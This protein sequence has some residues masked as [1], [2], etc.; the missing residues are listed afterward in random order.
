[1]AARRRLG[2]PGVDNEPAL[3]ARHV[4]DHG[5][6]PAAQLG[7]EPA[8]AGAGSAHAGFADLYRRKRAESSPG[9]RWMITIGLVLVAGLGGVVG[10]FMA[11]GAQATLFAALALVVFGPAVEEMV[12]AMGPAILVERYPWLVPSGWA[13]PL[14]TVAGGLGFAVIENWIYLN[15]Y[16]EDPTSEIIRWRWLFGP[17]VHGVSSLLV[18]VGLMVAWRKATTRLTLPSL[19]VGQGWVVAGIAFHG[20]YNLFAL[21]AAV[22]ELI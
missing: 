8:L 15:V 22:V 11:V 19:R 1:M 17:L 18:G 5:E 14:M 4:D 10:A 13:L 7:D 2:S 6:R 12:K 21:I 16:I 3:G 9:I 20:A